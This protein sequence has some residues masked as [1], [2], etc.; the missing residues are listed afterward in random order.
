MSK[1]DS[2]DLWLELDAR[3]FV[4]KSKG[5]IAG[6]PKVEVEATKNDW[7]IFKRAN[8]KLGESLLTMAWV[9]NAPKN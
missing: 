6:Y 7:K 8:R 3:T 4:V 2:N 5:N 9:P 1:K